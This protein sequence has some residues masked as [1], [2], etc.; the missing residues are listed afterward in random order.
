MTGGAWI[1]TWPEPGGTPVHDS[2]PVLLCLPP[3]GAGCHQFRA[4]QRPLADS[5]QVWGVQLPGR[6]NRWR[7]P[8]PDTFD[9]AV[10]AIADEVR[11]RLAPGHPLTIFGHSFGGLIGYELAR[12]LGPAALVVSGCRPPSHWDGAGRGIVEDDEELNKLLD[13]GGPGAA[14]L[15]PDTRTLM[16]DM[17]RRDAQ[18]S[19]SYAHTPG[20]RLDIEIH[21]WGGTA[22]ETVTAHQLDGWAEATTRAAHRMDF[23]GGH[24]AVLRNPELILPRLAD[25]IRAASRPAAPTH[26]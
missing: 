24:H 4:W 22:D 1:S 10:D 12:R 18:L 26:L 6:E 15:D 21:A 8:M 3:A 20:A 19:S 14:L 25:V 13:A 16:L 11:A 17:L 5:A 9:E 23:P 2:R 7:D